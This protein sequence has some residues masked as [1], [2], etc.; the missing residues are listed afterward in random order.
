MPPGLK[1]TKNRGYSMVKLYCLNETICGTVYIDFHPKNYST[2]VCPGIHDY[3]VMKYF[4]I[5]VQP[6]PLI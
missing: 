5:S 2:D 4:R 1:L 6:I 3:F